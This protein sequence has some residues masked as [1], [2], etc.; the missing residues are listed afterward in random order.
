MIPGRAD[1][2]GMADQQRPV[3][4][5]Y[6]RA[7]YDFHG[8]ERA[9]RCEAELDAMATQGWRMFAC[10]MERGTFVTVMWHRPAPAEPAAP[11]PAAPPAPQPPDGTGASWAAQ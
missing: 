1:R 11:A 9:A 10:Q 7:V 4:V 6:K 2:Q 3:L 5:Q 8:T